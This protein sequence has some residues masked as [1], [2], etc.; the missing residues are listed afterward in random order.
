MKSV[1]DIPDEL[2][3]D[4]VSSIEDQKT[5]HSL[6]LTSRRVGR[7]ALP[8]LYRRFTHRLFQKPARLHCFLRSIIRN[9]YLARETSSVEL[10][11]P[12]KCDRF[13]DLDS[14]NAWARMFYLP[15]I[16]QPDHRMFLR[17]FERL[18]VPN[19]LYQN[20]VF[21]REEAQAA[22]LLCLVENVRYLKIENPVLAATE[23]RFRQDHLLLDLLIPQIKEGNVLQ[24]LVELQATTNRLEGDQG[25]FR[26]S[27][28]SAF[29]QLP[30]MRRLT[31]IICH[32][33]EDADFAGFDCPPGASNVT[34]IKIEN[35]AIC[36]LALHMMLSA[37]KR[38]EVFECDWAGV[39]LGW[40][41][42]NFPRLKEGLHQHRESLK[43]TKLDARKHFDS[44]PEHD[45]GLVP[46]LGC[47]NEFT[48]LSSL[49]LPASSLIGWDEDGFGNFQDL[50][51]NLP[52]NLEEL[53]INQIAP[54]LYEHIAA[55]AEV[56]A[57]KYPKLSL[58]TI[59]DDDPNDELKDDLVKR[60]D[61]MGGHVEI[62]IEDADEI[63]HFN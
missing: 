27:A 19:T 34:E 5:L 9:A 48:V 17:A 35:S 14:W 24:R 22:L 26:L 39:A 43:R 18:Q 52:P 41:E 47:L 16:L 46:P 37:C 10:L 45:D 2:L 56:C 36:P 4:I 25:G 23:S 6:R 49:D 32:D 30:T 31:V 28:I 61:N 44:W 50:R 29:F 20:R 40:V 13:W 55:L 57:E 8:L 60:F 33:P 63:D 12:M 54:R 11:N 51:E 3:Q 38:I 53:K 62:I 21:E 1:D 59:Y 58:I 15:N 7:I 42:I